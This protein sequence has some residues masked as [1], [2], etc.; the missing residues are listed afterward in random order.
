MNEYLSIDNW[1]INSR[2]NNSFEIAAFPFDSLGCNQL[3]PKFEIY[4]DT[5]WTKWMRSNCLIKN[6]Y[7][8]R[9]S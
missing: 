7:W 4:L 8:H 5:F 1:K 2:I 9:N 3:L 6:A